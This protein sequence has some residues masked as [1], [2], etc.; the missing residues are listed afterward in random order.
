MFCKDSKPWKLAS[1]DESG[2][3]AG[4]VVSSSD[5]TDR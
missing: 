1:Q 5:Q 3:Q 2:W 4:D